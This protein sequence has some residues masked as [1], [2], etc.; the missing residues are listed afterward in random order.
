M[1]LTSAS[2]RTRLTTLVATLIVF[3]LLT[4]AAGMQAG[5]RMIDAFATTYHDRV[6]PLQQLK[7]LSDLYTVNI[8][9]TA[10]K[11]RVHQ[12]D[13]DAG[14]RNLA[15]A[16]RKKA[17]VWR[18]YIA[19]NLTPE[20]K[21]LADQAQQLMQSSEGALDDLQQLF[22]IKDAI[23]LGQFSAG[24]LNQKIDPITA[25]LNE[26]VALQLRVAAEEYNKAENS[27]HAS[28]WINGSLIAGALLL[29]TLIAY[30][31]IRS[32][33]AELGAEPGAVKMAANRIAS[34]DLSGRI[35][36]KAGDEHSVIAAMYAMQLKLHDVIHHIKHSADA[37][38]DSANELASASQQVASGSEQSSSSASSMAAA[39][40]QLTVSIG[41]LAHNSH[42]ATQATS[43]AGVHAN[44][45]GEVIKRVAGEMGNI[46]DAVD[47][48]SHVI[49]TLG[50]NSDRIS[51]VA[52][53]I[54]DVADQTNLLALNAAI[55]AARAGEH[56]RGF[57]VVA[58]EVRKL[59]ERTTQ[60]TL[61]IG[62]MIGKLQ[63]SSNAAVDSMH[64]ISSRVRQ[65]VELATSAG[66]SITRIHH[67]THTVIDAV[68][69]MSAALEQQRVASGDI[70]ASV[71]KV[72]QM[73]EETHAA[74]QTTAQATG[75]LETLAHNLRLAAA[76]FST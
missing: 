28:L 13:W 52:Q 62:E 68:N 12:L 14:L 70:A 9:A 69:T 15:E 57:A 55:E 46:A 53:V 76:Q 31:I 21:Q 44:E 8:V 60:S 47:E 67:H 48:A 71:E 36:K 42:G 37:V 17:D 75:Q 25:K 59:A 22:A 66:E 49:K 56:G 64:S 19:T 32:L 40:E 4:G 16:R 5:T 34:G 65:G 33:L 63:D 26:L 35:D 45:G 18:A 58:D 51:A 7:A 1:K 30:A 50:Q 61:E 11:V 72:A 39:I 41:Q 38:S 24:E 74:A 43:Q 23:A 54:K 29:G 73:S 6:L 10:N 3:I 20:E 2:V 27:Y